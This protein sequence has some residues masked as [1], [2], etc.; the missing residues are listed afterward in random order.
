MS[1]MDYVEEYQAL[2]YRLEGELKQVLL[3]P[4]QQEIWKMNLNVFP[5]LLYPLTSHLRTLPMCGESACGLAG[6]QWHPANPLR[7]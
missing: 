4:S 6:C 3:C 7:P 1:A 5:V 2:Q